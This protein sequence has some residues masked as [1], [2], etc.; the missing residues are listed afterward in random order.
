MPDGDRSAHRA[1]RDTA[2]QALHEA[3]GLIGLV[4]TKLDGTAKGGIV[5]HLSR[6][7]RADQAGR[8]GRQI[9]DLQ[10]FDPKSFVDGLVPA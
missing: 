4:L 7:G 10:P 6:A 9:E 3:V 8:N 2:G 5:V 1:E